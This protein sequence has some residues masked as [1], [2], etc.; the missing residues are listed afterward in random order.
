MFK[1]LVMAVFLL[2]SGCASF[3]ETKPYTSVQ[4]SAT[5]FVGELCSHSKVHQD[6]IMLGV[7]DLVE[8]HA[9][10]VTCNCEYGFPCKDDQ[11]ESNSS[12]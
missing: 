10:Y 3:N 9:I 1:Y 8:P 11:L 7:S 5:Y 6:I 12:K 2:S 4:N